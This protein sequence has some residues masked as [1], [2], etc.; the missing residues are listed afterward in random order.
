MT[1][2]LLN[3]RGLLLIGFALLLLYAW[4]AINLSDHAAKTHGTD[5]YEIVDCITRNGPYLGMKFRAKDGKFY[6]PCQLT[7][8]RIGLGIFDSGGN[9]ISAYVPGDGIWQEVR[10]YILQRAFRFTGKLPF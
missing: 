1:R 7:D 5:A 4:Y 8:G 9:N 10:D 3:P 6:I 2:A